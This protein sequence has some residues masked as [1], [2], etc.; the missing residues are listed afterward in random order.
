MCK[1][2]NKIRYITATSDEYISKS[3]LP[4]PLQE[5]LAEYEKVIGST[6]VIDSK[7]NINCNDCKE[8]SNCSDCNNCYGCDNCIACKNCNKCKKCTFSSNLEKQKAVYLNK[9]EKK[10]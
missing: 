10:C 2:F 8:C 3:R 5:R 9:G 7:G 6:K 4:I 1:D